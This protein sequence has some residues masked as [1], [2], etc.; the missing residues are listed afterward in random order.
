MLLLDQMRNNG[1]V[2]VLV[3][4]SFRV[5]LPENPTTGY[6]WH[7][8]SAGGPALRVLE[9]SFESS[10]SG[11]GSGGVRHWTFMADHPAEVALHMELRRSW[12][13]EHIE[14]FDLTVNVKA[15]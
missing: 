3:G 13:P 12:Q 4:D 2:E 8:Q 15:R 1:A 7:L 11:Y 9:D 14:A 6:R 10:Q 5:Q